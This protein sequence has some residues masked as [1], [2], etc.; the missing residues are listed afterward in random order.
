MAL[1]RVIHA[2]ELPDP[3]VLMERLAN[4]DAVAA[5]APSA[6]SAPAAPPRQE[7][8]PTFAALVALLDASGKALI[9]QQLHDFAGLVLYAPPELVIRP[10]KPL[11]SEFV[12]DLAAALKAVTGTVWQVR[13]SDEPAQPTLLEQE[14]AAADKVRDDVLASPLVSA[15]FEAF[16][17]AELAGFTLNDQRSA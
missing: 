8:P 5:R 7:T 6:A 10:A 12:R 1:L 9:A 13:A 11:S 3:G 2:S 4:G 14:K 15:A 16:P 17:E